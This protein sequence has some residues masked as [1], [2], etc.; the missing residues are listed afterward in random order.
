[1]ATLKLTRQQL[2]AFLGQDHESIKQFEK[3]FSAVEETGPDALTEISIDAGIAMAAANRRVS[4]PAIDYIDF[5]LNPPHVDKPGRMAWNVAD[6]TINIHHHG[7]VTQQVGLESYTRAANGT[8]STIINGSVVG[9]SGV[10]G[11][12]PLGCEPFIA[13]RSM[14]SLYIMGV[15]TQDIL[16]GDTGFITVR[17]LVH[18]L[19]TTGTPYGEA[20]SVG[21]ILY[22]SPA[23]AGWMTNIKPTA[24]DLVIPVAF[25]LSVSA[26]AGV[27]VCRPA[28]FLQ[29][30]YGAFYSAVNHTAALANTAYA[31]TFDVTS[32]S[33]GVSIGVPTSRI[34]VDNSGLYEFNFSIQVTKSSAAV[35]YLW[36]WL[37]K[38]GTDVANSAMR[39]AVQGATGENVISRSMPQ[40]MAAGDY[41]ELMWA[42]DAVATSLV[43]DAATAFCPATPSATMT[44]AQLNQ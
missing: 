36:A 27:I 11:G 7:D 26:T 1:M 2:S 20:W 37:R 44:V 10:G 14:P 3:L 34:V 25:V 41:I 28:V 23:T 12:G 8:G 19:D 9:F 30:Y 35:G 6:D 17:G 5:T 38:N 15:A 42:V 22:A 4:N 18:D 40:S 13:D 16:D 21:D 24:P 39:I 43:A 32:E 33:S 29:L 31:V